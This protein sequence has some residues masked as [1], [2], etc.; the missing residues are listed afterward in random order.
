MFKLGDVVEWE[1]QSG[2]IKVGTVVQV[3]EPLSYPNVSA[4][5][6]TC[7]IMNRMDSS[8]RYKPSY[9]IKV[10]GKTERAK[11]RIYWPRE[12]ALYVIDFP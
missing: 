11:P 6:G 7:K 5:R 8:P 1:L 12:S 4:M 9:L 10:L 3:I 2:K